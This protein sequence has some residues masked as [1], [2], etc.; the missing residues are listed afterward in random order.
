MKDKPKRKPFVFVIMPFSQ[1]F[2]DIY[3]LG[4]KPACAAA[5]AACERVDEQMFLENI[6]ERIYDQISKADL[7]VAE[8]TARNPNVF[9]EAG[10]AHGLGKPVIL[11]TQNSDDIPFD[12]QHYP[13]IVYQKS[14]VT[15]KE[16]LERK[17]RW[18]A[19]H[20]SEVL[21]AGSLDHDLKQMSQH[22]RNYLKA[23][24]YTMVSFE[25]I[26]ERINEDYSDKLLLMLINRS[27]ETFRRVRVKGGR[28][29][30]GLVA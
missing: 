25:R 8:M 15:L 20:P 1:D 16:Q 4:I 30:I 24:D 11:L 26:R 29:G 22:I 13:H 10:F 3:E 2:R 6:L 9:Y 18:C 23:H 21:K 12:L 14:I 27:P 17:I 19:D 7:V 5:G 28:P